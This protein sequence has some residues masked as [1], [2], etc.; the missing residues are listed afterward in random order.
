MG[1]RKLGIGYFDT[2]P[3]HSRGMRASCLVN[4]KLNAS[5]ASSKSRSFMVETPADVPSLC[6]NST[7]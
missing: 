1:G 5:H 7:S 2:S 3:S 6:M 4:E